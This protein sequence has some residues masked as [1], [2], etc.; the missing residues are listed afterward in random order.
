MI[1]IIVDENLASD[2]AA[3]AIAKCTFGLALMVQEAG[4]AKAQLKRLGGCD[5][6]IVL[7]GVRGYQKW[8]DGGMQVSVTYSS[9]LDVDID[10]VSYRVPGAVGL[11]PKSMC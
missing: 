8:I 9:N 4:L 11:A 3:E 6:D 1:V 5:C 10:A 7:E 2:K